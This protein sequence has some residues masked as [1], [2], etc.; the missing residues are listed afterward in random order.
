MIIAVAGLSGS[1]KNTLGKMIAKEFDYRVVCPTF[2]DLAAKEGVSLMEFHK[3]AENDPEIDKKFDHFIRE[4]TV[5]GNCVVTTWLGPW[6]VDADIRI[7]VFALAKTR[8]S[9]VAGR[10]NLTYEQA[11]QHINDRDNNN[12]RRYKKLYNIDIDNIDVFDACLNSGVYTPEQLLEIA[13][14]TIKQKTE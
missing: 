4:E 3:M 1:G 14:E 2:K 13:M 7:K 5:K 11:L 6:I 12:R 10:D 9:R 8:A